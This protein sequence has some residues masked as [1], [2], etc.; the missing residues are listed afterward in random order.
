MKLVGLFDYIQVLGLLL[1]EGRG[2]FMNALLWRMLFN[3]FLP[4]DT[5]LTDRGFC[6]YA[7]A[8][9]LMRRGVNFVMRNHQAR[10]SD[11]RTGKR[12]GRND[13]LI[14]WLRPQ[15]HPL[16]MS[17][18]EFKSMPRK[19]LLC[20]IKYT[21]I[22]KGFRPREVILVTSHLDAQLITTEELADVYLERWRVELFFDDIKT[23]STGIRN[24]LRIFNATLSSYSGLIINHLLPIFSKSIFN[25]NKTINDTQLGQ[26]TSLKEPDHHRYIPGFH[27]FCKYFTGSILS[28][29]FFHS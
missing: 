14:T 21:I 4:G 5:V 19:I 11:F 27:F 20:E 29:D 25:S 18:E 6:S 23:T 9:E 26:A 16:W 12:L 13:H 15:Q 10:K 3:H 7:T 1:P 2:A 24:K 22:E 8:S 28:G 17:L